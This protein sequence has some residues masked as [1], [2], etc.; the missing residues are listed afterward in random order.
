MRCAVL[1]LALGCRPGPE[2][3][4][5]T[6]ATPTATIPTGTT[7]TTATTP[8]GTTPTGTTPTGTTPTGTIPPSAT[9]DTGGATGLPTGLNG[10][11]P[12][13]PIGLP[14]FVATNRDGGTRTEVDLIGHPTALWF[15]PAAGTGG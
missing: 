6:G 13:T 8:T 7:P 3:G 12:A 11:P 4:T 1:L 2:P 14:T 15:Y 9:A 10:T 5:P